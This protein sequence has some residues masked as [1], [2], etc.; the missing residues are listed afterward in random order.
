M[1]EYYLCIVNE[2]V[3]ECSQGSQRLFPGLTKFTAC[4]ARKTDAQQRH[5]NKILCLI[6]NL[7]NYGNE[8]KGS[9]EATEV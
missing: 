1:K 2:S 6:K 5:E 9:R 8:S 3:R 4:P 7:Y